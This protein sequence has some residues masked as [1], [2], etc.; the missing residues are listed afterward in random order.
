M[1]CPVLDA[2]KIN[3]HMHVTGKC[4]LFLV[5]DGGFS[6]NNWFMGIIKW[7]CFQ[8]IRNIQIYMGPQCVVLLIHINVFYLPP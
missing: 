7:C 3:I 5:A 4:R 6:K 1:I 2:A 8:Y